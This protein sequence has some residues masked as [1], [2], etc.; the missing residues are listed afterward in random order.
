MDS[1]LTIARQKE[2]CLHWTADKARARKCR[3]DALRRHLARWRGLDDGERDEALRKPAW[4]SVSSTNSERRFRL[5]LGLTNKGCAFW[6]K[7]DDKLGCLNCGYFWSVVPDGIEVTD[8]QLIAQFETGLDEAHDRM[9]RGQL[10]AFDVVEILN[11]GSFFNDEEISSALRLQIFDAIERYP[12]VR[13]VLVESR[14]EYFSPE[15]V[16]A[17]LSRLTTGQSLEIAVGLETSDPFVL[18]K[19]VRKGFDTEDFEHVVEMV[20]AYCS[21]ITGEPLADR[22]GILGYVLVKPAYLTEAEAI[23]DA[24]ET[25]DYIHQVGVDHGVTTLAKLE[26]CVV[27]TGTLLEALYRSKDEQ[28]HPRYQPPSTWTV[29]EII[30]QLYEKDLQRHVR[31]GAREDMDLYLEISAAY[32]EHG[33]KAGMLSQYDFV[34]YAA[35]QEYNEHGDICRLMLDI[36]MAIEE[37]PCFAEWKQSLGLTHPT[38]LRLYES[39]ADPIARKRRIE[40]DRYEAR[41]TFMRGLFHSLDQLEYGRDFQELAR[42]VT[43]EEEPG[44]GTP[45][46]GGAASP[47]DCALIEIY[48]KVRR[49]LDGTRGV[50]SFRLNTAD[51]AKL[52]DSLGL[53]RLHIKIVVDFGAFH[54][55]NISLWLGIPTT[56]YISVDDDP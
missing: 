27:P 5:Q 30:A 44:N 7:T 54:H 10:P 2:I 55:P 34:L 18:A 47:S 23:D 52:H 53:L 14:P 22:V 46:D 43:L 36:E 56:R 24:I 1:R 20:G 16:T 4:S 45:I 32:R 8:D 21:P 39:L 35:I 11:D 19:C 25:V 13:R 31:I 3:L 37:D 17:V 6:R 40:A 33:P 42:Q 50:T 49:L 15:K 51:T 48:D 12:H 38:L 26:P 9:T 29:A 41:E 28:G